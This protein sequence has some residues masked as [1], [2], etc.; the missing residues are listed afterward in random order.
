MSG[1][2][3]KRRG[4]NPCIICGEL[5]SGPKDSTACPECRSKVERCDELEAA[6]D[7]AGESVALW[8]G[9]ISLIGAGG[10]TEET[11][12]KLIARLHSSLPYGS[13]RYRCDDA[14]I[15]PTVEFGLKMSDRMY[16]QQRRLKIAPAG[17][18]QFLADLHPLVY[19]AL[20]EARVKG[21][22]EGANLLA[23][24][25]AGELTTPEFERRAGITS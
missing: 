3:R 10:K 12:E 18:G 2:A 20:N 4:Y 15:K 9:W 7:A 21:K 23:Q 8:E 16:G 25:A 5:C 11:L 22:Q 6:R 19:N 14:E 24:L 13:Q 17:F 1:L